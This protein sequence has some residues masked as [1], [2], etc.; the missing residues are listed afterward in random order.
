MP[1]G[2]SFVHFLMVSRCLPVSLVASAI[3]ISV[4]IFVCLV[5]VWCRFRQYSTKIGGFV[6]IENGISLARFRQKIGKIW[7]FQCWQKCRFTGVA[8]RHNVGIYPLRGFPADFGACS[9]ICSAL[10]Q[11]HFWR[12][13]GFNV[14]QE[15]IYDIREFRQTRINYRLFSF[16]AFCGL[17]GG[18]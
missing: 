16:R 15:A 5:C 4:C 14:A 18:L 6:G 3:V 11:H 7:L 13:Q 12:F 8:V 9:A 2:C 10:L 17:L 1:F